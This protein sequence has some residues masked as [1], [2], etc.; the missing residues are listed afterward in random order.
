MVRT[1]ERLS[2]VLRS[3]SARRL[4]FLD[5]A[6]AS[7]T[8]QGWPQIEVLV[9]LQS[10]SPAFADGVEAL[11]KRIAGRPGLTCRAIPVPIDGGCDGRARL[12]NAGVEAAS[13]RYLAFLDDDD[14]VYPGGYA[15]LIGQLRSNPDAALAAGGCMLADAEVVGESVRVRSAR[16]GPFGWGRSKLDLMSENF[17]PIH[18]FVLD[19]DRCDG[20]S[21]V[22]RDEAIPLE[23]YDFLLRFARDH[24]FDLTQ[25]S[26]PVCEYRLHAGNTVLTRGRPPLRA[27]ASLRCARKFIEDV[28]AETRMSVSLREW[29]T[30]QARDQRRRFL[31]R[32]SDDAYRLL[33]RSGAA[34]GLL[35]A[36]YRWLRGLT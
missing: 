7:V 22:F 26:I 14:V 25:A 36:M 28:K 30:A 34:G 11:L 15:V 6:L 1:A 17:I 19:R 18:S 5:L 9:M 24:G 3:N 20:N 23:D 33:E 21:L 13:G 32:R 16:P 4:A 2:V 27:P 35:V 12:L 31:H 8:D 29:R 10:P